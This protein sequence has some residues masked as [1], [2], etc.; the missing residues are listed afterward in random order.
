MSSTTV[1]PMSFASRSASLRDVNTAIIEDSFQGWGIRAGHGTGSRLS[2]SVA[3]F[4]FLPAHKR[5]SPSPLE[6]RA[7]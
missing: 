4:R 7:E 5:K 6:G 1:P 3:P 2:D